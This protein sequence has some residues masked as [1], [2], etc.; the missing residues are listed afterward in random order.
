[1]TIKAKMTLAFAALLLLI[2]GVAFAGTTSMGTINDRLNYLV[3]VPVQRL[4]LAQQLRE[5]L[6]QVSREEKNMILE[7][8]EAVMAEY[9]Q[10]IQ[11]SLAR[12]DEKVAAI[13]PLIEDAGKD[14]LAA[15]KQQIVT[16]RPLIAEIQRLATLNSDV[17]AQALSDGEAQTAF[18]NGEA[19]MDSL[20]SELGTAGLNPVELETI[21]D[22]LRILE[23]GLNDMRRF[24]SSVLLS[25]KQEAIDADTAK[26]QAEIA[27]VKGAQDALTSELGGSFAK[28]WSELDTAAD[29][30]VKAATRVLEIKSANGNVK[31]FN[32]SS[33]DARKAL[34]GA[35]EQ[36]QTIVSMNQTA[37]K[38]AK[39][40]SDVAYVD[41]RRLMIGLC[42]GSVVL[43]CALA[44][45]ITRSLLRQLGGEP[46]EVVGI[47]QKV[48]EGDL[49]MK[50]RDTGVPEGSIYAAIRT[51]VDELRALAGIS[52]RIAEGD[53]TVELE[54]ADAPEGSIYRAMRAMTGQLRSVV[55]AVRN[56]TDNVSSS[57]EQ[58]GT[59]SAQLA[60]GSNQQAGSVQE[61]S[62]SIEQM[63]ANIKQNAENAIKTEELARASAESADASGS[64]MSQTVTAMREIAG[65]V[66]IIEEIARQTNLLALNA[67]IEA[68]RAGEHGK[69]FAVVAAEVRKL[70]ERSQASAAEISHVASSSVVTAEHAGKMLQEMLPNIRRTSEL[71][72]EITAATQEQ[73][74][75]AGQINIA[76]QQL[77]Q[78]VQ[79]NAAGAEELS[80]TANELTGQ[81]RAL[82]QVVSFFRLP[83]TGVRGLHV[84]RAAANTRPKAP[85]MVAHKTPAAPKPATR[86]EGIELDLDGEGEEEFVAYGT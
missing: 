5:E 14:E 41:A 79:Q 64:A 71:V 28:R 86:S 74:Q 65:K 48:A 9:G 76:A 18:R 38:E 24:E 22:Q 3:D 70:A 62:S 49:S 42:F 26:F 59:T 56:A 1:M 39:D 52:G 37:M 68:A 83:G 75:G 63:A 4:V 40:E 57:S 43:G 15:F 53:L 77:D 30:Y 31:A 44:F 13:E 46:G 69:G 81:A 67:A 45:I 36:L 54:R 7:D 25:K 8:D 55:T 78:V 29:D 27:S 32:L 17:R 16:Y 80:T 12:I 6:L 51:M 72:A 19:S 82:T 61:M 47:A 35:S 10:S 23:D 33:G 11:A 34:E 66:T 84:E 2:A 20:R 50:L 60:Q 85:T 58:V 21:E 73:E